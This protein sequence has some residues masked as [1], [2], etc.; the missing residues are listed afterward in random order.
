MACVLSYLI[1][2]ERVLRQFK[3]KEKKK[4]SLVG[5]VDLINFTLVDLYPRFSLCFLLIRMRTVLLF[6]LTLQK[7]K[8]IEATYLAIIALTDQMSARY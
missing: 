8:R 2:N 5:P 1:T 4:I 6:L 7:G 3:M